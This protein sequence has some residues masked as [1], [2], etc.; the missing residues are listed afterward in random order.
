MGEVS[1]TDFIQ[2]VE[3]RPKVA[4][5]AAIETEDIPVIDLSPLNSP[6]KEE[7]Q[8]LVSEIG[9]ACSNWGFF[10][11]INHGVPSEYRERIESASRKFFSLSKEEK[12]TVKKNEVSPMGYYD[13]EHTQNVRDWKEV[14]DFA[15][16]DDEKNIKQLINQWPKYP[17]E[18]RYIY[19]YIYKCFVKFIEIH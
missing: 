14:F 15:V 10:Q 1:R 11:V 3:H 19:I 9:E 2:A 5:A 18:L 12:S 4:A 17:P 16:Q 7:L 8:R 6:K 13:T